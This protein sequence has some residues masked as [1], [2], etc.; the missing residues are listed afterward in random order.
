MENAA[1]AG[2]LEAQGW[3][4]GAKAEAGHQELLRAANA[5]RIRVPTEA[6]PQDT[7]V[8]GSVLVQGP[9]WGIAKCGSGAL[10]MVR[11]TPIRPSRPT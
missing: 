4:P 5:E 7:P 8:R 11:R 10:L 1:E 9:V 3:V 2:D 6:G